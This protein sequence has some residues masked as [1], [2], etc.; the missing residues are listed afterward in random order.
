MIEEFDVVVL[1]S[2]EAGK[3]LAWTLAESGMRTAMVERRWIGGSCP[4]IACLPTK[5]VIHSAKVASLM[6]RSAEFGLSAGEVRVDME[7]V[8][9][10]KRRMVDALVQVHEK[11]YAASG[12]ELV[13]GQGTFVAPRTLQVAMNDGGSRTLRGAKVIISTGSRATIPDLPGMKEAAPM[14]HIEALE[15]DVVP[16]HLLVLGGGYIGL[17]MAQAMRRFGARVTIVE[18]NHRVLPREDDDAVAELTAMCQRE[19]IDVLTGVELQ[20]VEGRSGGEVSLYG[21]RDGIPF[22]ITG[23]HLLASAG[24]T[25]NNAGIGLEA[26]GVELTERGFIRVN[27]R[28]E[29]TAENTWAVGD[30]AG[31]PQFTHA[32]FDDFRIVRDN[33]RG[34]SRSTRARLMPFA[35]F[36]DPEFARVGLS[37]SEARQQGIPY[38]LVKIPMAAVLRTRTLSEETG[39]LKALLHAENDSI[40]GFTAVGVEA[41]EILGVVE[42]AMRTGAPYTA[43]RDAVLPH[44]TMAEGLTVLFGQ[45]PVLHA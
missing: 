42:L 25:P 35:L 4:N 6:R 5:N 1:G 29:T 2:G 28:L 14:T 21:L 27:D 9:A 13:L 30:C 22:L 40:L 16:D 45:K 10:R 36:T 41:G 43:I 39:F 24:R 7:G 38:R 31:S 26:A 12:T 15:L 3:Y 33:L 32:A 11:R 18:R 8:R 34:G 19:G 17:E 37:E 20:R 44:P 23:S